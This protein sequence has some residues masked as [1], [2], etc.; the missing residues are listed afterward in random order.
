MIK[1]DDALARYQGQTLRCYDVLEGQLTKT[2][3]ASV[4]PG[5]YSAVDFHFQPWIHLHGMAGLTLDNHPLVT[6]WFKAISE[7][8]PVK[9]AYKKLKEVADKDV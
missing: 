9:A 5:G 2:D 3:G 6:K 1:N 4:L 8:E 7:T